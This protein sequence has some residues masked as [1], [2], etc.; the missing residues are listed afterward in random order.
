[1]I[2]FAAVVALVLGVAS[3]T[4]TSRNLAAE[5][6]VSKRATSFWYPNMDHAGQA[7]GYAPDLDGDYS[8]PVYKSVDSGDGDAIQRAINNNNGASRHGQWLASQPRVCFQKRVNPAGQN[9]RS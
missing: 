8:Y 2:K 5:E 7:R 1:M 3:A 6:S 4:P 9:Y